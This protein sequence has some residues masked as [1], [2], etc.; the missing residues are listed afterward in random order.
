MHISMSRMRAVFVLV[1]IT[2]RRRF[3]VVVAVDIEKIVV[4][5]PADAHQHHRVDALTLEDGVDVAPVAT[6]LL[7]KPARRAALLAQFRFD[8]FSYV[9][10]FAFFTTH[11][12]GASPAA[13]IA[14][15]LG[16]CW[17]SLSIS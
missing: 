11:P 16:R 6:Q 13:S 5:H 15:L 10:H 9:D 1:F 4:Q 14:G 8:E 17:V 7:G 3:L 2:C 12:S